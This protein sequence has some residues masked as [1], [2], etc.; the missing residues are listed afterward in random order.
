MKRYGTV[1]DIIAVACSMMSRVFGTKSPYPAS[2]S[3]QADLR[4]PVSNSLPSS[5][6]FKLDS[7]ENSVCH[8]NLSH[9]LIASSILMF[10]V[11]GSLLSSSHQRPLLP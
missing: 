3:Q 5:L 11:S 8:L 4:I 2:A 10:A 7:L 9:R 1:V 6:G